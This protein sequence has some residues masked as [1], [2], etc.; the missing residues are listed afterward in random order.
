M[1]F[2]SPLLSSVPRLRHAFFTR[3][4]GVSAG[5]YASLNGGVGSND[6]PAHVTENRR[7]M[8]EYLGVAPSHF[9]SL[10]QVHSPDVVVATQPWAADARPHA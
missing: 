2:T 4:G 8:A 6:D 7:R 5:L 1:M 10:Y 3:E 9:L